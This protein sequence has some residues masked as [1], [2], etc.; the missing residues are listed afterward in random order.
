MVAGVRDGLGRGF[1][2]RVRRGDCFAR[3]G[4]GARPGLAMTERRGRWFGRY[5]A[6]R[7]VW[8]NRQDHRDLVWPDAHLV[9]QG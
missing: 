2:F 3:G 9:A 1:G 5:S 6:P 8:M 4:K 7:I